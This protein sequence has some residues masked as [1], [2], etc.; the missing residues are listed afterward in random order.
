MLAAIWLARPSGSSESFLEFGPG[1]VTMTHDPFGL[2]EDTQY[3]IILMLFDQL[4][5]VFGFAIKPGRSSG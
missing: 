5:G 2:Q 4:F 1:A 3:Y